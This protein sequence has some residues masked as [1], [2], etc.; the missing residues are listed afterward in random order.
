MRI[1]T[2]CL[3]PTPTESLLVLAGIRSAELRGLGATLSMTNRA[4]H[5]P[6]HVL[7][8]QLVGQQDA[9]LG[10]FK[11]RRPFVPAAWKILGSLSELNIGVKQLIKHKW[12]AH[13]LESTSRVPAFIPGV[14]SRPLEMSLSRTSWERLNRLRTDV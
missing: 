9:H 3:R 8:G 5:D 13:Y 1:V 4:I 11:L 2:G 14:S 12:N 10:K 6:D 7:H